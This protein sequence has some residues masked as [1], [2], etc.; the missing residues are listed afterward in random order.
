MFTGELQ[1]DSKG[2]CPLSYSHLHLAF[3]DAVSPTPRAPGVLC[4]CFST[5]PTPFSPLRLQTCLYWVLGSN[6]PSPSHH[7]GF[8]SSSFYLK[9]LKR[10]A[11]LTQS[12]ASVK[13]HSLFCH[14][15]GREMRPL[16]D[17]LGSSH[18]L[19]LGSFLWLFSCEHLRFLLSICGTSCCSVL[20]WRK[21]RR[22]LC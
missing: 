19:M 18:A 16:G 7:K 22:V 20:R 6:K 21:A 17:C 12:T 5:P 10:I 3:R 1:V 4:P 15:P 13:P 9:T 8:L 2:P 14:L 11:P